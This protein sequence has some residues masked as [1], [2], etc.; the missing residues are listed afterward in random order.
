MKK[1]DRTKKWGRVVE[2]PVSD[3][4]RDRVLD[5]VEPI[6]DAHAARFERSGWSREVFGQWRWIAA[7]GAAAGVL[8]IFWSGRESEEEIASKGSQEDLAIAAMEAG[9]LENL[10]LLLE[11]DTLERLE[12]LGAW[13]T[14]ENPKN[15]LKP[16]KA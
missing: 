10:D 7:A 8:A 11:F 16:G 6:L 1:Q 2:G 5:T 12:A 3:A 9:I 15:S 4:H 14:N 13:P